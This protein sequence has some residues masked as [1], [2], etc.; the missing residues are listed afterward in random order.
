M[1]KRIITKIKQKH[2]VQDMMYEI[3]RCHGL[4]D[5]V[6][7]LVDIVRI[8]HQ[9]DIDWDADFTLLRSIQGKIKN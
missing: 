8:K 1:D 4:G 3:V 9:D 2:Y 5:V 7:M 6:T